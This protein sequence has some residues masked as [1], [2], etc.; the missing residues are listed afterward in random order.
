MRG[1][2]REKDGMIRLRLAGAADSRESSPCLLP[3]PIKTNSRFPSRWWSGAANL[4]E[5]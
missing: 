5:W 4:D 1:N 3:Y 2:D